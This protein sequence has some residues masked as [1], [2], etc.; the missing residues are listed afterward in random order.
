MKSRKSGGLKFKRLKKESGKSLIILKIID[1]FLHWVGGSLTHYLTG[2]NIAM[3]F[4]WIL[5]ILIALYLRGNINK[6]LFISKK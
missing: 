2:S 4:I 1:M 3:I 6:I 5:V